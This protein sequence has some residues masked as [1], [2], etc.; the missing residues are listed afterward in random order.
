MK[1]KRLLVMVLF[2]LV[3]FTGCDQRSK[4]ERECAADTHYD[5]CITMCEDYDK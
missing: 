4:C 2:V 1:L 3:A 5:A